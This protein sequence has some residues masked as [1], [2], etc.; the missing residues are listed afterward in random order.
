MSKLSDK[1]Y[2]RNRRKIP[3]G[4][5]KGVMDKQLDLLRML[6][7]KRDAEETDESANLIVREWQ[8]IQIMKE[9]HCLSCRKKRNVI[10]AERIGM[11][12]YITS[13]CPTPDCNCEEDFWD[14]PF[15][16]KVKHLVDKGLEKGKMFLKQLRDSIR[17]VLVLQ[18]LGKGAKDDS[19]NPCVRMKGGSIGW[20]ENTIRTVLNIFV[21][22]HSVK[23]TMALYGVLN[24]YGA[25]NFHKVYDR[26]SPPICR[27][28]GK[29]SKRLM[30]QS[31]LREVYATL[32][33]TCKGMSKDELELE[34]KKW[35]DNTPD[36]K[37]VKLAVSYDMGWQKRSS[38]NRYDSMSGH[39]VLVGCRTKQV[40]DVI[41][42][43]KACKK[44]EL[45]LRKGWDTN[46]DGH[47]C[48]ENMGDIKSSKGMEAEGA[49]RLLTGLHE[50]YSVKDKGGQALYPLQF[51]CLVTDDDST[52]RAQ[53]VHK[54][55]EKDKVGR[56]P[57]TME[58]ITFYCDP[59]HRIKCWS[60]PFFK[61]AR[62]TPKSKTNLK[63]SMVERLKRY[64]G[65]FLKQ[66]RAVRSLEWFVDNASAP[67]EHLF[68]NHKH[69]DK[70]WCTWKDACENNDHSYCHPSW[71]DTCKENIQS[72]MKSKQQGNTND[73][74]EI[75]HQIVGNKSKAVNGDQTKRE[76]RDKESNKDKETKTTILLQ[77]NQPCT[78][79]NERKNND[80]IL[81]E[82]AMKREQR[83]AAKAGR[84]P[85]FT[86]INEKFPVYKAGVMGNGQRS[87]DKAETVTNS[88]AINEKF[89]N[90]QES[91]LCNCGVILCPMIG[92]CSEV[93]KNNA[94][95]N[96]DLSQ[97]AITDKEQRYVEQ[98]YKEA[99]LNEDESESE[100]PVL[101]KYCAEIEEEKGNEYTVCED[102]DVTIVF[103]DQS[104]G[105]ET[106]RTKREQEPY[107]YMCKFHDFNDYKR[108]REQYSTYTT[109]EA[110]AQCL[111][112]YDTQKN[113]SLNIMIAKYAPKNKNYSKSVSLLTRVYVAVG[114]S[115]SR[116]E[117]YWT[118]VCRILGFEPGEEMRRVLASE[119]RAYEKKRDRAMTT[120]GKRKRQSKHF[121]RMANLKKGES[122]DIAKKIGMYGSGSGVGLGVEPKSKK[123]KQGSSTDKPKTSDGKKY[124]KYR[125]IC[126]EGHEKASHKD[127]VMQKGK[128]NKEFLSLVKKKILKKKFLTED[129]QVMFDSVVGSPLVY[130]N[131]V[132]Q[133][134]QGL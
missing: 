32:D 40:I 115:I 5:P 45:R 94:V 103:D 8:L 111:H 113:E 106:E 64:I 65:Y 38:G 90:Y 131:Y 81:R 22:G 99:D 125:M 27:A 124:C 76:V 102:G 80:K 73:S 104:K 43:S 13:K 18:R 7:E 19:V 4:T 107:Y 98:D 60:K 2:F 33:E 66:N 75:A 82:V 78:C 24:I 109:E 92:N 39:G 77:E 105:K 70:S 44:C 29:E 47:D 116:K 118:R 133:I 10:I 54:K 25:H 87:A 51:D 16:S 91:E 93:M 112:N 86:A 52:M 119:D 58:P 132:E 61:L 9:R 56:L 88:T 129:E 55:N 17:P 123:R 67:L 71:C 28:I 53:L 117:R 126:R 89:P 14:K 95:D 42:F 20:D 63:T 50:K 34:K 21:T 48:S 11:S 57:E 128:E 127:C 68:N 83:S 62:E 122:S 79:C 84:D 49:Y 97:S 23:D 59:G 41:V 130:Q 3:S 30:R 69:C 12:K 36:R 37:T 46:K 15:F 101:D 1:Y 85:N 74:V 26:V 35:R 108:M 100:E 72:V 110:L 120:A 114:V 134:Q 31:F 96:V 6:N 121:Q